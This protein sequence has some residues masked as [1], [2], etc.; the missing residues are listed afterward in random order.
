MMVCGTFLAKFKGLEGGT[1]LFHRVALLTFIK[2]TSWPWLEMTC[3]SGKMT[4]LLE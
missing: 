1:T 3:I 2:E 4:K